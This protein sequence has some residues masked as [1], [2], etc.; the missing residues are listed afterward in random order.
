MRPC[1]NCKAMETCKIVDFLR[2]NC[3]RSPW[4]LDDY[5]HN[6]FSYVSIVTAISGE[7]D[8]IILEC[9]LYEPVKEETNYGYL[10]GRTAKF[11]AEKCGGC[12]G[13]CGK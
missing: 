3:N 4:I 10:V 2:E 11:N 12:K 6:N 5:L 7:V 13:K 9:G 8:G 1:N